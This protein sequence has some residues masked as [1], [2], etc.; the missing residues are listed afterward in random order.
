VVSWLQD[1]QVSQCQCLSASQARGTQKRKGVGIECNEDCVNRMLQ[2]ECT[3]RTCR[4][5][6]DG[7]CKNQQLTKHQVSGRRMFPRL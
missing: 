5:A 2:V 7:K 3:P 4:F 1:D 6:R